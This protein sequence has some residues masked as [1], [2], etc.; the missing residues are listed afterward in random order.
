MDPWHN[1]HPI[2]DEQAA[3]II[4]GDLPD[5]DLSSARCFA[6]G[7]DFTTFAVDAGAKT[8]MFRF[9]KRTECVRRLDAEYQAVDQLVPAFHDTGLRVPDYRYRIG[10]SAGY[11]LPYGGYEF[12]E[13]RP[14]IELSAGDIDVPGLGAR[15]GAALGRVH[16]LRPWPPP[17]IYRDHFPSYVVDFRRELDAIAEVL[18]NTLVAAMQRLMVHPEPPFEGQPTFS[19]ADLGTEHILVDPTG[20]PTGII[21]WGDAE[22]GDPRVD[23]VGLWAWAGD[24]VV[25]AALDA[26]TLQLDDDD[27]ARLRY[28]GACICVGQAFYGHRAGRPDLLETAIRWLTRMHDAGQLDDVRT[29]E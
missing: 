21:D 5:L 7:W 3:E 4:R 25:A 17:R 27:W 14:L 13:G 10:T 16:G 18:P 22:W 24:G 1:E 19:H 26:M 29:P 23:L 8:W 11:P 12:I 15:I 28:R 6:E 9:P 20:S 2:G